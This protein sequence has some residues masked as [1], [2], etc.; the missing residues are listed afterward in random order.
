MS[1]DRKLTQDDYRRIVEDGISEDVKALEGGR[2]DM[3]AATSLL[4]E[5]RLSNP[6][7]VPPRLFDWLHEVFGRILKGEAAEEALGMKRRRGERK[8]SGRVDP[9]AIAMF[10]ELDT[11]QGA[12]LERAMENAC[13]YFKRELDTIRAA[14]KYVT[15]EPR[16]SEETMRDYIREHRRPE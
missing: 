6:Q 16:L 12:N 8:K 11:R 3:E 13:E 5:F 10:V 1:D 2:Q 7:D 9:I 14:L 4:E 15:V